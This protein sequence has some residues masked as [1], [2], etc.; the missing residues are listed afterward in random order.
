LNYGLSPQ[1]FDAVCKEPGSAINTLPF[2]RNARPDDEEETQMFPPWRRRGVHPSPQLALPTPSVAATARSGNAPTT[3]DLDPSCLHL[4]ADKIRRLV[5]SARRDGLYTSHTD[6]WR[7]DLEYRTACDSHIPVTPEWLQFPS[8][9]WA[10]LDG[11]EELP[12][13]STASA[14]SRR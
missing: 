6:R 4:T 9:N 14:S 11:V 2:V 3:S 12:P 1:Q 13:S 10:R 8:G 7:N 5:K